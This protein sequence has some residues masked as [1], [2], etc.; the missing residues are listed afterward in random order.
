MVKPK[1]K[2][3]SLMSMGTG[4]PKNHTCG[5]ATPCTRCKATIQKGQGCTQIPKAKSGFTVKPIFCYQCTKDIVEQTR[6][7]LADVES[8]LP[9]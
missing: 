3:P 9:S 4:K 2:T 8:L 6:S 1:G 5:K 7:D